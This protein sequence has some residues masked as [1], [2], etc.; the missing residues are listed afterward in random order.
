MKD[1]F[2]FSDECEDKAICVSE[3]VFCEHCGVLEPFTA[4][5]SDGG[6]SWCMGCWE[7]SYPNLKKAVKKEIMEE[8]VSA[9]I[10]YYEK[11]LELLKK[12]A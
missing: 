1:G 9:K 2:R 11:R 5:I 7:N 6:T 4:T 8:E 12:G 10:A 3:D